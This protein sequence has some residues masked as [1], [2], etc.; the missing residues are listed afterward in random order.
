MNDTTPSSNLIFHASDRDLTRYAEQMADGI[1]DLLLETASDLIRAT[2]AENFGFEDVHAEGVPSAFADWICC[3]VL[4]DV[5]EA[6]KE[7]LIEAIRA[8]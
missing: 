8:Y 2:L 6:L 3:E 1:Q 4:A 5:S 7:K